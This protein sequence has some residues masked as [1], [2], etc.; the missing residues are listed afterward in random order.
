MSFDGLTS[1]LSNLCETS[2]LIISSSDYGVK[3]IGLPVLVSSLVHK[4]AKSELNV[5]Y[6]EID[7]NLLKNPVSLLNP[8]WI[9]NY[10]RNVLIEIL[11][12]GTY[13]NLQVKI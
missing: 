13:Q 10:R 8:D 3:F 7:P 9:S 12:I 1:G 11:P 4:E 6:I 5:E 2:K